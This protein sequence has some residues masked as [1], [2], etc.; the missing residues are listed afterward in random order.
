MQR[1]RH[2][3]RYLPNQLSMLRVAAIPLLVVL[4]YLP[5]RFWSMCAAVVFLAASLTDILDGVLARRYEQES[6]VGS[7]LD[8]LA[9]KLIF[10]SALVV[11]L[12][13]DLV[14]GWVVII[15]LGREILVNTLRGVAAT[16]GVIIPASRYGK[17]KTVL[18]VAALTGMLLGPENKIF[19]INWHSV[20]YVILFIAMG[21][22]LGSAAGY[23]WHY[24]R[25]RAEGGS[26]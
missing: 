6:H 18:Q 19:G 4:G 13:N 15:L 3:L 5:G 9:D 23:V 26:A 11:L 25:L 10:M 21:V 8:P 24:H 17:V 22:S 14:A 16:E 7:I 1:D 12:V 20:G 2:P